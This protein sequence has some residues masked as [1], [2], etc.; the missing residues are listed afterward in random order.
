MLALA[1]CYVCDSGNSIIETTF[2]R[3]RFLSDISSSMPDVLVSSSAVF[4]YLIKFVR[5]VY[6]YVIVEENLYLNATM[7]VSVGSSGVLYHLI[8]R[9]PRQT[10]WTEL[11]WILRG[12]GFWYISHFNWPTDTKLY[13]AHFVFC[14]FWREY[15]R[16]KEHFGSLVH[17]SEYFHLWNYWNGSLKNFVLGFS[18]K[19]TAELHLERFR[20]I[21]PISREAQIIFS[22]ANLEQKCKCFGS[23]LCRHCQGVMR[24]N[25]RWS[26]I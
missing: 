21:D 1:C 8:I 23:S 10:F 19:V 25:H 26:F 20:T 7:C 13:S 3:I 22:H 18:L 24:W 5:H 15:Y 16:M 4:F 6:F 11:Q 2:P 14:A 17:A 9:G 12:S